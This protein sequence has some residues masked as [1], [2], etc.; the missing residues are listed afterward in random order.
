M[1]AK[2]YAVFDKDG[3][4]VV[5]PWHGDGGAFSSKGFAWHQ[6]GFMGTD[7]AKRA[8]RQGYT[9]CEVEIVRVKK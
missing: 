2:L 4:R 5:P 8:K 1:T 7:A 6:A 9:C 3:N